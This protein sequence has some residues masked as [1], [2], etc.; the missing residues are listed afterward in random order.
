[1]GPSAR[2]ALAAIAAQPRR[3]ASAVIPVAM[4]VALVGCVFFADASITHA[5]SHQAAD[6]VTA[7]HVLSGPQ[8]DLTTLNQVRVSA[9]GPGRGRRGPA[10]LIAADPDLYQL[11]GEAV[12]G[13]PIGQVIDLGVTAGA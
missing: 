8:L 4:A 1:M 9:R 12:A 13:G 2:L 11:Y 10:R 3:T 7:G 6:T 5:T